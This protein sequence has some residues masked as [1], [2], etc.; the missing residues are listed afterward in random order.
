MD[1]LIDVMS[2][3]PENC[4]NCGY[5]LDYILFS[6]EA[7]GHGLLIASCPACNKDLA[8]KYTEEE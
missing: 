8:H 4:N 5:L 3:I 2:D 7:I 1:D 6:R